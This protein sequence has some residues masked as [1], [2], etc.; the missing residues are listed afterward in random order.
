MLVCIDTMLY[1]MEEFDNFVLYKL[2]YFYGISQCESPSFVLLN[3]ILKTVYNM[4]ICS[5]MYIGTYI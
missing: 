4:F 1:T 3:I 2:F 5:E